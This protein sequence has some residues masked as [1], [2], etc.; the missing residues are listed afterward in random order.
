M[1]NKRRPSRREAREYP[2]GGA[3]ERT[4]VFC[5]QWPGK[6]RK[7]QAL[8]ERTNT[9][10]PLARGREQ[11]DGRTAQTRRHHPAHP[12]VKSKEETRPRGPELRTFS[13]VPVRGK[14]VFPK[15]FFSFACV[16]ASTRASPHL[17]RACLLKKERKK[18]ENPREGG[19]DAAV[20]PSAV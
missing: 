12:G 9:Q 4:A 1:L 18:T 20:V 2:R 14:V 3:K 17:C 15:F 16:S 10:R 11:G 5:R 13:V 19:E 8:S 7:K 6:R